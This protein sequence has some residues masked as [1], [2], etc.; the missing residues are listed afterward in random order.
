MIHL[1]CL[2]CFSHTALEASLSMR[3]TPRESVIE[4]MVRMRDSKR[5]NL[6][7]YVNIS[8][9]SEDG[10]NRNIRKLAWPPHKPNS[11]KW[12]S[13]IKQVFDERQLKY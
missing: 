1:T 12:Q 13:P 5:Y 10:T 6:R 8:I 2:I 11:P 7:N 3:G 4:D 9:A